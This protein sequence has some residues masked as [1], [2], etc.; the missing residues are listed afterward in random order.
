MV[1]ELPKDIFLCCRCF[2][3]VLCFPTLA[4][5]LYCLLFHLKLC[6]GMRVV[7]LLARDIDIMILLMPTSY[8]SNVSS[9]CL[10]LEPTHTHT[11]LGFVTPFA[12]LE[13]SEVL[14]SPCQRILLVELVN[15]K[16][17]HPVM[18]L[19]TK[20]S[21]VRKFGSQKI[22]SLLLA[23]QVVWYCI[24][25][26][27]SVAE[28]QAVDKIGTKHQI[29]HSCQYFFHANPCLVHGAYFDKQN[30]NHSASESCGCTW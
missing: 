8:R 11:H 15:D 26:T 1:S 20:E 29:H 17:S 13:I 27:Q 6:G 19:L 24:T 4:F 12:S 9:H 30:A 14:W 16:Y 25:D 10:Q 28:G 23:C 18:N 3:S 5:F 7:T 22:H 21:S 2:M